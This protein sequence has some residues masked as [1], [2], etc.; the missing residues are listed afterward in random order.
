MS[1]VRIT[2]WRRRSI[3]CFGAGTFITACGIRLRNVSRPCRSA[4]DR[5]G[6][7]RSRL[8]RWQRVLDVGCGM[9]GSAIH[10]ARALECDVT[11][12]TLSSVQR[13]WAGMAARSNSRFPP[14]PI[15]GRRRRDGRVPAGIVRPGVEHRVHRTLVRQA[16]L[17]SSSQR[18]AAARRTR[19][20]LR[21][22][23]GRR[24][25]VREAERQVYDVCEGFLCP[26]L[27][28]STRL[29]WLDDR[30]RAPRRAIF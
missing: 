12:I 8:G 18:A 1:S 11:G 4:V 28:C 19:R 9:G 5:D 29:P 26:S 7:P 25:L 6:H 20:D 13:R 30:R 21:V 16:G 23:S 15:S 2:I 27:G 17:F 24:P 14:G 10:L 22:A 3:G